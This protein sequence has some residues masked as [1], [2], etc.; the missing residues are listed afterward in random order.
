MVILAFKMLESGGSWLVKSGEQMTVDLR[1]VSSNP[2]LGLL[3]NIYIFL[4][5][6]CLS[7]DFHSKIG[8]PIFPAG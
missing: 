4:K 2:T 3:K 5:V 6:K 1:V 7:Q 8:Y